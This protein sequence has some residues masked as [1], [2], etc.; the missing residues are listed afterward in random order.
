MAINKIKL[1]NPFCKKKQCAKDHDQN[2]KKQKIDPHRHKKHQ[3][4]TYSMCN[5]HNYFIN[6]I[7]LILRSRVKNIKFFQPEVLK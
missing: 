5:F 2:Q 3:N 6:E 1:E 4:A 7:H